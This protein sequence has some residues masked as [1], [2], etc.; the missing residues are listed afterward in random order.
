MDFWRVCRKSFINALAMTR[1]GQVLTDLE[2]MGLLTNIIRN[3]HSDGADH[4]ETARTKVHPAYISTKIERH[5][6]RA[7]TRELLYGL[8][9]IFLLFCSLNYQRDVILIGEV[10]G[11]IQRRDHH[12][13]YDC[14]RI[15]SEPRP[16]A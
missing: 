10:Q 11:T 5:P 13:D 15:T 16:Y 1:D 4:L 6:Q 8:V 12:S 2:K 14:T 9:R 7:W 3:M